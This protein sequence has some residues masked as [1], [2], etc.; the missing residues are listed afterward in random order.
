MKRILVTK[1]SVLACIDDGWICELFFMTLSSCC[2]VAVAVILI[3]F[4]YDPAPTLK[5]GL[6][7]NAIIAILA[8]TS[9]SSL[10]LVVAACI[11]QRKWLW[12]QGRTRKLNDLQTFDDANRFPLEAMW[13]LTSGTA[14]STTSLGAFV[15]L[16]LLA[17]DPSAQQVL[18]YTAISVYALDPAAQ[19]TQ[20]FGFP[21]LYGEASYLPHE[22]LPQ[23]L[24]LLPM[25]L[26][27]HLTM[28]EHL[29]F[30]KTHIL[31]DPLNQTS[32][33]P[34]LRTLR[35]KTVKFPS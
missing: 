5:Y 15:V 23:H 35:S 31:I 1:K 6:T 27:P 18:T 17:F 33:I 13:L 21:F 9:K 29:L 4:K 11:G 20:A 34:N 22:P 2:C 10:S 16:L 12:Q 32:D 3:N 24:P 30:P 25:R 7:L 19:A 14:R 28:S 8:T 26:H